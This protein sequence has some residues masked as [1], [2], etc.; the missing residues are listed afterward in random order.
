MVALRAISFKMNKIVISTPNFLVEIGINVAKSEGKFLS[1][2]N[3]QQI[4]KK[5]RHW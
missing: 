4:V 1:S 2:E 5:R 3:K